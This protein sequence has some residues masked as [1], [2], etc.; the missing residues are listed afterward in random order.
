MSHFDVITFYKLFLKPVTS[1]PKEASNIKSTVNDNELKDKL[2]YKERIKIKEINSE[3]F[4]VTQNVSLQKQIALLITK[5][6]YEKC[7]M[8]ILPICMCSHLVILYP[9]HST[10]SA[11]QLHFQF[12]FISS[13][14]GFAV[15]LSLWLVFL[16]LLFQAQQHASPV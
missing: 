6:S 14:Q 10:S 15:T 16:S 2:A 3:T 12:I 5:H 1:Q 11:Q 8:N 13:P 4:V 7:F 9:F